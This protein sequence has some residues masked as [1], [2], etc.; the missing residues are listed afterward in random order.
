MRIPI[1]VLLAL[2]VTDLPAV[3]RHG[4]TFTPPPP[5]RYKGPDDTNRGGRPGMTGRAIP[6][7]FGNR[8]AVTPASP[9]VVPQAS[10]ASTNATTTGPDVTSWEYWWN[11]NKDGY[12]ALKSHL[13]QVDPTTGADEFFLGHG[14]NTYKDLRRPTEEQI[15]GRVVPALLQA[16]ATERSDHILTAS[17]IALGK[18]GSDGTAEA[19]L[20]ALMALLKHASQEVAET[21]AVA[22]GILG[23]PAGVA[24]LLAL[25]HDTPEGRKL[26]GS[27]EVPLRTRAFAGYGLGLIGGRTEDLDVRRRIVAAMIQ[28]LEGPKLSTFDVQVAAVTS[29][30]LTPLPV[31][32]ASPREVTRIASGASAVHLLSRRTQIGYLLAYFTPPRRAPEH[33]WRVRAHVPIALARLLQGAPEGARAPVV[34][35][36]LRAVKAE[37]KERDEVR[38]AAVLALGEIG[39][40][41]ADELDADIRTALIAVIADGELLERRF[42]LV[43]LAQVGARPG[44][45]EAPAAGA[46]MCAERLLSTLSRGTTELKPWSGIALGILGTHPA[47]GI[48]DPAHAIRTPLRLVTADCRR[49]HEVGA[50]TLGLGIMRDVG[51][52][53]L[54]LEKLESFSDDRA[55]GYV[56]VSLGLLGERDAMGPIQAMLEQSKYRPELLSRAAIGLGLIG[57]KELVLQLVAMLREANGTAGQ[58]AISSAL[59]LV[60]DARAIEP[61]L[62]MVSQRSG[63]TDTARAFAAVALGTVCDDDPLPW[64]EGISRGVHYGVATATLIGE[65]RGIL[66][67]L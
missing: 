4:N 10:A 34:N 52:E 51:A 35:S 59:G 11:Y 33:D 28:V 14:K 13:H 66:E 53:D 39:D 63:L 29:L 61:L 49:P 21:A 30:G 27:H 25:W 17:S 32:P 43:A 56:A 48:A 1:L 62:E 67:I 40:A 36:L 5:R 44:T 12:L 47:E 45:G 6:L 55:R 22:I 58:A 57:D 18:I 3:A 54:M 42:A 19:Q 41:D 23:D 2:A 24:P 26:S 8:P 20:R 37:G 15:R 38:E 31:E 16:I 65:A 50:Y 46:Q 60:G 7:P 9:T 64:N